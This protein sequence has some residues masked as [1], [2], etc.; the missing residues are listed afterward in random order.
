MTGSSGELE[1][2]NGTGDTDSDAL[3]DGT[4][5]TDTPDAHSVV[6]RISENW[7]TRL[8]AVSVGAL[9]VAFVVDTPSVVRFG[10]GATVFALWMWWFVS[11]GVTILGD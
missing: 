4:I 7:L 2:G 5:S 1:V 9:L 11:T 3:S 10:I 6:A 8:L